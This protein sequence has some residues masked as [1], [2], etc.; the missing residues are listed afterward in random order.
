MLGRRSCAR[1]LSDAGL[2]EA[3]CRSSKF[4]VLT[5]CVRTALVCKKNR[6]REELEES[7]YLYQEII[8]MNGFSESCSWRLNSS[9]LVTYTN[10]NLLDA[11]RLFE[12]WRC[13][14]SDHFKA[15]PLVDPR[16]EP[17]PMP[18]PILLPALGTPL[19]RPP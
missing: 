1:G 9:L 18:L 4:E 17:L 12:A 3:G 11:A 10:A 19:P 14:I 13:V 6:R 16:T 2:V 5:S 7:R 8:P 15:R